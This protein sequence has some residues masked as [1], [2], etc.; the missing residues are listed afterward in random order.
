MGRII[1]RALNGIYGWVVGIVVAASSFYAGY[2]ILDNA[3]VYQAATNVQD[4]IRQLKPTQEGE[5][6]PSFD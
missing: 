3:Q 6:G 4:Q 5:S 1:L 2:A